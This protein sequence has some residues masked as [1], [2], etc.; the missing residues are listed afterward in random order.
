VVRE[1][2]REGIAAAGAFI[3]IE[4]LIDDVGCHNV[5]GLMMSLNM[6][7]EFGDGFDYNVSTF[8]SGASTPA[9]DLSR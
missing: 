9:S 5:F 2:P 7:I 3:V 4:N 6:L 1:R 8:A